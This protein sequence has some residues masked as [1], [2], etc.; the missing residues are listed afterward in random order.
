MRQNSNANIVKF[1]ERL[2]KI[3][4]ISEFSYESFCNFRDLFTLEE[5]LSPH[6]V[7]VIDPKFRF[8]NPFLFISGGVKC[9]EASND[10]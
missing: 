7:T 5:I 8:L 3:M 10:V 1:F 6:I 9:L 2:P 4:H